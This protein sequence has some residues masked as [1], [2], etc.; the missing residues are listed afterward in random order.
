[1]H[2]FWVVVQDKQGIVTHEIR[3]KRWC[4]KTRSFILESDTYARFIT[5]QSYE[6]TALQIAEVEVQAFKQLPVQDEDGTQDADT[7]AIAQDFATIKKDATAGIISTGTVVFEN[8]EVPSE[9]T[10][11]PSMGIINL[12]V[13]GFATQSC[14]YSLYDASLAIDGN[15]NGDFAR[16]SVS[17]TCAG[18]GAWWMVDLGAG[19]EN[20]ID[21]VALFNRVDCCSH[22]LVDFFVQVLNADQ[23]LVWELH[24]VDAVE[25][26]TKVFA[27][28][29]TIGR[30]VKIK[31]QEE[32]EVTLQLAEVEVYGYRTVTLPPTPA[33]ANLAVLG[34]ATQACTLPGYDASLAIDGNS[35]GNFDRNSVASTCCEDESPW[36]MVD[37]GNGIETYVH[38]ITVHNRQ[39][40]KGVRLNDFD[41]QVL[42]DNQNVVWSFRNT[43]VMPLKKTFLVNDGVTLGRFVRIHMYRRVCL[44]LAEVEVWGYP[45]NVLRTLSPTPGSGMVNLALR[46]HAEQSCSLEN[47]RADRAIDGNKDPDFNNGSVSSTCCVEGDQWWQVT[48]P[49]GSESFIHSIIIHN[50][51]DCC[52]ERLVD[53]MIEVFDA[54]GNI[55]WSFHQDFFM[56]LRRTYELEDGIIGRTVRI[57]MLR[58]YCL[59]LA[60][61]EVMGFDTVTAAPTPALT[62]LALQRPTIQTCTYLKFH[63]ELAVDGNKNGDLHKG[64]V[65]Q[66]C[67]T[68]DPWWRVDLGS[69]HVILRV[70]IYNRSDCCTHRLREFNVHVMNENSDI[71]YTQYYD[72]LVDSRATLYLDHVEGRFVQIQLTR[73]DTLHVA[74]VE[75]FGF[76]AP[77]RPVSAI[78]A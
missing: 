53:F 52:S 20:Y 67:I 4:F 44:Q 66:T 31:M 36:W 39:G 43:G 35:N 60:E 76:P 50:R 68:T 51:E 56:G 49:Y 71:V 48:F 19:T 69:I 58:Q 40:D 18:V 47:Y 74:E 25:R 11:A 6:R 17:S 59:Q 21:H 41:V 14:Q 3:E 22:R 33:L 15:R 46:G 34:R 61:V 30:F 5:I 28:P 8:L 45:K 12:A 32:R 2:D 24:H 62:N 54:D 77:Q 73:K 7:S 27:P 37:L 1:L 13:E 10:P 38:S 9:P 23:E 29:G 63:P 65:S 57:R 16:A 70:V 72:S 78:L 64:S 26:R 42:D 55:V 75:V